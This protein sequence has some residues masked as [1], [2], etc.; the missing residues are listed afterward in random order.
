M[1]TRE[2]NRVETLLKDLERDVERRERFLRYIAVSCR[3]PEKD[4]ATK[5]FSK[6]TFV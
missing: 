3:F 5:F 4:F 2:V 6:I 1:D